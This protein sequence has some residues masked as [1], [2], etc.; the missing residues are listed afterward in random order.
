MGY[1]DQDGNAHIDF[2]EFSTRFQVVVD[3]RVK[4]QD[5][6]QCGSVA[7]LQYDGCG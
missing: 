4:M 7:V 6:G 5:K 2:K 1:M 3:R